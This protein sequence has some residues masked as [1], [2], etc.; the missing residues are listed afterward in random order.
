MIPSCIPLNLFQIDDIGLM[1][2]VES[3][4]IQY[5]LIVFEGF[6]SDDRLLI[7]EV[8][9]GVVV[10]ALTVEDVGDLDDIETAGIGDN[11]LTFLGEGE[12]LEEGF[13]VFCLVLG[14]VSGLV[15]SDAGF[16]VFDANR[17]EQ[18]VKRGNLEGID[19]ILII[20]RDEND[21][22][23][24][25]RK[26]SKQ[27]ETGAIWHFDIEKEYIWGFGIEE[28]K[29]L[30]HRVGFSYDVYLGEVGVDNSDK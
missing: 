29:A 17:F 15:A 12:L 30:F 25:V 2:A 24:D 6:G 8:E 1:N 18:I 28:I 11:E 22:E 14:W 7:V 5:L 20:C 26:L 27:F 10:F 19:G 3:L 13:Q 21:V 23:V 16:E 4:S 9:T